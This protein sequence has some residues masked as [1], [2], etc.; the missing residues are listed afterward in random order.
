MLYKLIKVAVD[1]TTIPLTN[2]EST[3]RDVVS[4]VYAGRVKTQL[5]ALVN[6]SADGLGQI[7]VCERIS[8]PRHDQQE[9]D[10]TRHR[11]SHTVV[12]GHERAQEGAQSPLSLA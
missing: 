9:V 8:H 2:R 10:G 5:F 7:T 12:E 4:D 1:G 3:E 11:R 6:P